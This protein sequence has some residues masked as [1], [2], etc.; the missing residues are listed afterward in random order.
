MNIF[1]LPLRKTAQLS[2]MGKLLIVPP[3]W[4]LLWT[5]IVP[6]GSQ[7]FARKVGIPRERT[8]EPGQAQVAGIFLFCFFTLVSGP[9]D[10]NSFKRP[11]QPQADV[12]TQISCWARF[13]AQGASILSCPARLYYFPLWSLYFFTCGSLS[14]FNYTFLC[15]RNDFINMVLWLERYLL[16]P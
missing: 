12:D 7:E 8:E 9:E 16:N 1:H 15:V 5:E 10:S 14:H 6:Q 11:F 3:P 2:K 13:Q 4:R